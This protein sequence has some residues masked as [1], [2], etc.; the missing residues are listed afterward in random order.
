MGDGLFFVCRPKRPAWYQARAQVQA[1]LD[2][3]ARIIYH[4]CVVLYLGRYL[5]GTWLAHAGSPG[6]G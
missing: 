2:G 3:L 6:V 4:L 5:V 1:C